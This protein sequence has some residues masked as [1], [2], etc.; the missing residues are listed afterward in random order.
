MLKRREFLT[1]SGAVAIAPWSGLCAAAEEPTAKGRDYYLLERYELDNDAQ[2]AR[3]DAFMR[4]AAIPALNR[5]GVR[6]VGVFFPR[7]AKPDPKAAPKAAQPIVPG[8]SPAFVLLRHKSPE[9][10][11]SLVDRLLRDEQFTGK[12]A[13]AVDA[14]TGS[15]AYKRMES[16]LHLAFRG[17]PELESPIQS[18]GRV[19]QLRI[20]ESPSLR[21]ARKKIEMFNDAG[22][23]EVFRRVGLNPVFFGETLVGSKMPNLTYML[24]FNS[25]QEQDANWK[26]FGADPG[27]LRLRKMPEYADKRI[28][29]GITN[30][31]LKPADYSQI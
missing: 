30:L 1:A 24:V 2:K 8:V 10:L 27:W 31:L 18:P 5:L 11:L 22:E 6:P 25:S 26:K 17:M 9:I 12:G 3:F 21:C 23:I 29:C 13:D 15:A 7:E 16:S 20:Y 14:I 28:L 19:F 4:D